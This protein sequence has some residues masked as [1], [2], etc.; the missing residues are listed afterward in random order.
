MMFNEV[1]LVNTYASGMLTT[2]TK[3]LSNKKVMIVFPP[4]RSVKYVACINAYIGIQS[5][6]TIINLVARCLIS[7]VVL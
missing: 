1:Y 3:A 6:G 2:Q 5:A 4:E 7:S